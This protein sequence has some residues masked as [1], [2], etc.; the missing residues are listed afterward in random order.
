MTNTRRT[1]RATRKIIQISN[2]TS[3]LS[4]F[5]HFHPTD[6]FWLKWSCRMRRSLV[7]VVHY[8]QPA[9]ILPPPGTCFNFSD[10]NGLTKEKVRRQSSVFVV[11]DDNAINFLIDLNWSYYVHYYLLKFIVSVG[12][13]RGRNVKSFMKEIWHSK[14]KYQCNAQWKS[15]ARLIIDLPRTTI[16]CLCECDGCSILW[17]L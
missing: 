1:T 8:L 10:S 11:P 17:R 12:Y 16:C 3:R 6:M 14:S 7:L 4:C 2:E 9:S 5:W 13:W 15:D